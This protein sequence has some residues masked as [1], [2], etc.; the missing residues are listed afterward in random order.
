MGTIHPITP[1]SS[2]RKIASGGKAPYDGGAGEP[3]MDDRIARIESKVTSLEGAVADMKTDLAVMKSNYATR[4]DV[5]EAK[6][7]I[8]KWM[9]AVVFLAQILPVFLKKLGL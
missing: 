3:P 4:A 5:S 2:G 9:V 6:A 1:P 8:I 7:D